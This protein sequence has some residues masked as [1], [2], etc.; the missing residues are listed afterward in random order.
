MKKFT[1][2]LQKILNLREFEEKEAQ[3]ELARSISAAD[4]I[5][6]ELNDIAMQKHKQSYSRSLTTDI[7]TLQSIEYFIQRLDLRTEE[8]LEDLTRAQLVIE[9]K[10][11]IM[12]EKMKNRKVLTKLKDKKKEEHRYSVLLN[13]EKIMDDI[14]NS[15]T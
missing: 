2:S 15:N 6:S 13:E 14:A 11:A 8:L 5:Q 12:A 3:I 9:E 4:I 7:I 10:R 1:F